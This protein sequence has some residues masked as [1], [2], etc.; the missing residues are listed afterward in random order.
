[1]ARL[2]FLAAALS[3]A[4]CVGP[5]PL[6]PEAADL[7]REAV[8]TPDDAP[9]IRPEG[10]C[11]QADVRPAVIETVTEQ[12]LLAPETT[13]PDGST[14]PATFRSEQRQRIVSERATVWVRTPCPEELTLDA[15]ATLQ[16]ALKARGVYLEPVTGRMD[17]ATRAAVRRYQAPRG[18]DS[19]H[20]SL[21]AA[22]ELGVIAAELPL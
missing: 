2:A 15:I 13:S 1:M 7:A 6:P 17:A 18:L 3:L 19:D 14:I 4:A 22:R 11:W 10:A 9:P 16:R 20:L 8:R 5:V 12:I 21:A